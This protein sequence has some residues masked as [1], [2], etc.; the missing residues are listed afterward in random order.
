[1]QS[2]MSVFESLSKGGVVMIPLL[3]GG[4]IALTLVLERLVLIHRTFYTAP[5]WPNEIY[6]SLLS[7]QFDR[8]T[9]ECKQVNA[10]VASV[11]LSGIEHFHHPLAEMELAMKNQAENWVPR[12]EKRIDFID[13]IITAAPLLGL[14]GTITG[15]M[16]SFQVLSEKG[17]NDPNAITGGVAEALIAT[18][19]GLVIALGCLLAYNHLTSHVKRMIFEMESAASKL[20]ELRL[21]IS[22][23]IEEKSLNSSFRKTAPLGLN[24]RV[25]E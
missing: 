15:M 7:Q 4:F 5:S 14:L 23:Q 9:Q 11:L 20:I 21:S 6:H 25:F 18:A 22:R 10:P 12:L 8:A 13:T 19:T 16:G 24:E 1:M 2:L 3:L 17:V